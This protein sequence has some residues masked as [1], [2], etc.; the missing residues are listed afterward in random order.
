M[1]RLPSSSGNQP[2]PDQAP[3]ATSHDGQNR[4]PRPVNHSP[5]AVRHD[6]D[7][8]LLWV[9]LLVWLPLV[10]TVVVVVHVGLLPDVMITSL[11]HGMSMPKDGNE[12][13]FRCFAGR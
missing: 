1:L 11:Y 3:H 8:L 10:R 5:V 6:V 4:V 12:C 13:E 2:D 7:V 9:V